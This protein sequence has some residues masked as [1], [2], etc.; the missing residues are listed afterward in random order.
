MT[1]TLYHAAVPG[2]P[3]GLSFTLGASTVFAPVNDERLY[4]IDPA[5][6]LVS[7]PVA[8]GMAAFL[9]KVVIEPRLAA[10]TGTGVF[11]GTAKG[12]TR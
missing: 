8:P 3:T 6:L 4:L 12:V 7:A 1:T 9:E 2:G 5:Q 11:A 10:L